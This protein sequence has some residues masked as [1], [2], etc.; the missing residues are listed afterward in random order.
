[1]SQWL[2]TEQ[3]KKPLPTVLRALSASSL[4]E[5]FFRL[6]CLFVLLFSG[7]KHEHEL[8]LSQPGLS[9]PTLFSLV[10]ISSPTRLEISTDSLPH[11][12]HHM[13]LASRLIFQSWF[14]GLKACG[15]SLLNVSKN[16]FTI[17]WFYCFLEG[18]MPS[19]FK[20][21]GQNLSLDLF[22]WIQ[23]GASTERL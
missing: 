3:E 16:D 7:P 9:F 12:I 13:L 18:K 19:S 1:M 14:C 17:S 21:A 11:Y 22:V 15:S 10:S 2:W 23:L 20:D 4:G 6:F 8:V 5:G